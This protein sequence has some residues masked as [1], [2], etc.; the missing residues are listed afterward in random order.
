MPRPTDKKS[1]IELSQKNLSALL[2]LVDKIPETATMDLNGRDN[3]VRD[4]IVHLYEWQ[5]MLESF[6]NDCLS[7]KVRPFLPKGVTWQ[8]LELVNHPIRD[9]HQTTTLAEALE[10]LYA[11]HAKMF[12]LIDKH[13][14]DELFTKK[15]YSWTGTTSLGAYFVSALSSHYDWAIKT[16]KPMA[17]ALGINIKGK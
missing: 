1:L 13:D 16:I 2:A 15:Y 5:M 12:A 10:L 11:S 8:T 3:N 14:D 7:G 4:V 6:H 17:K 9:K